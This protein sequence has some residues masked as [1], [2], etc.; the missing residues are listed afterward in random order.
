MNVDNDPVC[1]PDLCVDLESETWPFQDNSVSEIQAIHVLEH[2]GQTTASWF[3]I[4]K[5]I[6]RVCAHEAKIEI[7]VPHPRHD[8][9]LIDPTHVRPIFPETIALFDQMR[10]IKDF[11][12]KGAESKLGLR[13]GIDIEVH[14]ARYDFPDEIEKQILSG[15]EQFKMSLSQDLR[16]LNN[17]SYQIRMLAKA[18]KP[19]RGK[20][21][22]EA[23][24]LKF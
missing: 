11:E 9:F 22:L 10:N 19:A 5:E 20:S 6:Y 21:W 8:N 15:D 1:Q 4:W 17:V 16:H 12:N 14:Q 13:L 7:A 2:M 18:H 24:N 23:M 3:H